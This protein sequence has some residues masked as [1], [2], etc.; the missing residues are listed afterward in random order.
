MTVHWVPAKFP[1][2]FFKKYPQSVI[3][4]IIEGS[5]ENYDWKSKTMLSEQSVFV[6]PL[7]NMDKLKTLYR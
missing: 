5:I 6:L 4:R 3:I 2:V 7:Y 1:Y